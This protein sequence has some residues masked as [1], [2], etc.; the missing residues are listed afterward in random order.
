MPIKIRD[1]GAWKL[2]SDAAGGGE[3]FSGTTKVARIWDQK[4]SS[5]GAGSPD[6]YEAWRT[7]TLNQKEDPS[8]FVTLESSIDG[9]N[10]VFSLPSGSYNISWRAPAHDAANTRTRLLYSVNTDFSS[11]TNVLGES[12]FS[13][14]ADSESNYYSCGSKIITITQRTYFAVQQYQDAGNWGQP[15]QIGDHEIYTQVFIEDLAT[16]VKDNVVGGTAR[17]AKLFQAETQG[18]GG[19]TYANPSELGTWK[20]RTLNAKTDPKNFV[21]LDGGNVYF[22][23]PAGSYEI[24]WDTP[25]YM[26]GNYQSRLQ[27]DDDSSFSSPTSILGSSEFAS[28]NLGV[29]NSQES[30]T[31]IAIVEVTET[32]YFRIQLRASGSPGDANAFGKASNI[33]TE[34]YTQVSV[35]DLTTAV[36]NN[37]EYVE[38]VS[39]VAT[40]QHQEAQNTDAGTFTAGAWQK[41]E[42]TTESDPNNF[43]K[44]PVTGDTDPYSDWSLPAGSYKIRWSA[45]GYRVNTH[46]TR[47][48]YA[49][50]SSFT[51]P[52]YVYG[53]SEES[54]T[55]DDES[56]TRSFGEAIVTLTAAETWFR[57]EHRCQ[58]SEALN[59]QGHACNFATEVYT[60]VSIEDLETAVKKDGQGGAIDGVFWENNITVAQDYTVSAEKNAMAAGPLSINTGV[61]IT[62]PTGSAFT[63]V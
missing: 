40:L 11:S 60:L 17:V 35:V 36:Q 27:Y 34:I 13:D 44:F 50:N 9:G 16:A 49:T 56:Q 19:G 8:S 24:K 58:T 28:T 6:T 33:S 48:I 43:V 29:L 62:V 52:T 63:I 51:S 42:L 46:Q 23:V 59:G 15:S 21:T 37:A 39:K 38:G 10:R 14:T 22:S 54:P 45:P 57:V 31:G 55:V 53:S 1:G 2:V 47:L 4:P 20:N 41:R 30:S 61:T 5:D 12:G 25:G 26:I 32:T 18:T 7:R 3:F